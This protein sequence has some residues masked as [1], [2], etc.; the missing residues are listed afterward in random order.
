MRFGRLS[1]VAPINHVLDGIE[2]ILWKEEFL[3]IVRPTEKHLESLLRCT[4]QKKFHCQRLHEAKRII[5]LNSGTTC[6]AAF[7][8]NFL[9]TCYYYYY[10]DSLGLLLD[11]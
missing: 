3:G 4:L 2:I 7:H 5:T 1:R 9:T 8:H 10:Y 11:L 6:D